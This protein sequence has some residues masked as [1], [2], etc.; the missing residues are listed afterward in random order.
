MSGCAVL[1]PCGYGA[2]WRLS[3]CRAVQLRGAPL[4]QLTRPRL[5]VQARSCVT[6]CSAPL[7]LNAASCPSARTE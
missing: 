6:G 3:D 2:A 4:L 1:R 7:L 5:I